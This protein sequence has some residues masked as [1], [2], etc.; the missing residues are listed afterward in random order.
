MLDTAGNAVG[1]VGV[2]A[3]FTARR[4]AETDSAEAAAITV[5]MVDSLQLLARASTEAAVRQRACELAAD[6]FGSDTASFWD[7]R[8]EPATLQC[9]VPAGQLAPGSEAAI[10][11][12]FAPSSAVGH[13]AHSMF[14]TRDEAVGLTTV[15]GEPGSPAAGVATPIRI[16]G[17][18]V[19]YLALGWAEPRRA[20][21]AAWLAVVDRF[22]VNVAVALSVVRRQTA[23]EEVQRL[24][25]RLQNG[26]LPTPINLRP[27]IHAATVYR[28]GERRLMLGGDFLDLIAHADGRLSFVVGD[29]AGHG[30]EQA[31]LGTILRSAWAGLASSGDLDPG[32]WATVL[33]EMLVRRREDESTFV[34]AAMGVLD[35]AARTLTYVLAGHPP[36]LQLVPTVAALSMPEAPPLGMLSSAAE[37]VRVDLPEGFGLLV[38]TDGLYDGFDSTGERLGFHG[39][40]TLVAA[41]GELRTGAQLAALVSEVERM[42]GGP[43]ADDVAALLLVHDGTVAAVDSFARRK[44]EGLAIS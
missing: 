17:E 43:L 30:P 3:D 2:I 12:V 9:R 11:R 37:E 35:P 40:H 7:A 19:A 14:I 26:L 25:Q 23:Q 39:L 34:T 1:M 5:R 18:V 16:G 41:R 32:R 22:A 4:E 24:A 27:P 44:S 10:D 28:P 21:A 42:N 31:A 29:V 36:P 33:H 38:F 8:T 13:S 6:L 20:P 15:A